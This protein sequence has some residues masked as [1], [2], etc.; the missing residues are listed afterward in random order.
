[1]VSMTDCL[2][3]KLL[4]YEI[5]SFSEYA[6]SCSSRFWEQESILSTGHPVDRVSVDLE[7]HIFQWFQ[8]GVALHPRMPGSLELNGTARK[9]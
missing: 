9:G 5:D 2:F 8:Q 4:S 1:M 7:E 3:E 6:S